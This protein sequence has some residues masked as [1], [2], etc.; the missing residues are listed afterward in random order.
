V[1]DKYVLEGLCRLDL[2]EHAAE[3]DAEEQAGSPDYQFGHHGEGDEGLIAFP[4]VPEC[5]DDEVA[6]EA[7]EEPDYGRTVPCVPALC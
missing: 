4:V 6:G 3:Q 2:T 1:L 7:T 5:P